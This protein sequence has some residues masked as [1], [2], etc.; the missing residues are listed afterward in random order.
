MIWSVINVSGLSPY[1]DIPSRN[2]RKWQQDLNYCSIL[3]A[4]APCTIYIVILGALLSPFKIG[5]RGSRMLKKTWKELTASAHIFQ[6]F[7]LSQ[8]VIWKT[9]SNAIFFYPFH[10]RGSMA[11][12]RRFH[13][14]AERKHTRVDPRR[15]G[16]EHLCSVVRGFEVQPVLDLC[17]HRN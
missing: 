3:L 4:A 5:C 12:Q 1:S 7:D 8:T 9:K 6:Y 10:V 2:T 15:P 11:L 13:E 16:R 14:V 17:Q